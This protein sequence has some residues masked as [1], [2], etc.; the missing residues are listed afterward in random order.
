M[1]TRGLARRMAWLCLSTI[2]LSCS[3]NDTTEHPT[4]VFADADGDGFGDDATAEQGDPT[5]GK[6]STGGDCND[7]DA[8]IFPGAAQVCGDG[9]TDDDCDGQ[10]DA[11]DADQDGDGVTICDNDCDDAVETIHPAAPELCNTIDDDC[12]QLVDVEDD[13]LV[14]QIACGVCPDPAEVGVAPVSFHTYNPCVLDPSIE[15]LCH[16]DEPSYINTHEKGERLHRVYHRTDQ[17]L[18]EELL[19]Y[20]PPGPGDTSDEL[21]S[22]MANTG[23]RMISLGWTNENDAFTAADDFFENIRNELAYGEDS[24]PY[25]DVGPA[26]SLVGRLV[27]LLDFLASTEPTVGWEAYRVPG[28]T[29]GADAIRWDLIVISGWSEGGAE[30]A[31]LA[32]DHEVDSVVL[33]SG[34]KDVGGP[35]EGEPELPPA[36]WVGDPRVTPNCRHYGFYHQLEDTEVL[37]LSWQLMGLLQP[38]D[39]GVDVDLSAPPYDDSHALNTAK[40]DFVMGAG[41]SFHG[42]MAKDDCI[43]EDLAIPYNWLFCTAGVETAECP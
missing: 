29:S 39:G 43:H 26:D 11:H 31:W 41:C 16:R 21:Y 35:I 30:A 5:D 3:A 15:S 10:V 1:T 34:P 18:R 19:L 33:I 20:L 42:A 28:Q 8:A 2:A 38:P 4:Q 24:S 17:P 23:Y 40:T 14:E 32:R 22:W 7:A 12:D 36:P 25:V 9:S 6:V 13:N 27:T 37:L